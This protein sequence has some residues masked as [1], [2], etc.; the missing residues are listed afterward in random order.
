MKAIIIIF[1]FLATSISSSLFAQITNFQTTGSGLWTNS[2]IWEEKN[3]S[4][5]W[6]KPPGNSYPGDAHD[7][8]ADV[9]INDGSVVAVGKD[10]VV[11]INSL[12]ILNGRILV[13]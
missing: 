1:A 12:S 8:G 9:T 3:E 4:G 7:H 5:V 11:Q 10:D 6:L 13:E 2:Q